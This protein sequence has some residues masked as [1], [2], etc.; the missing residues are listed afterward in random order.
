MTRIK[1]DNI[2]Q[3]IFLFF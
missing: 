3:P 1:L 2:S